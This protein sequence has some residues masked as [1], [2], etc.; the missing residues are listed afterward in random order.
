[1]KHILTYGL[2]AFVVLGSLT[3]VYCQDIDGVYVNPP[4][5]FHTDEQA[6]KT[7]KT[8]YHR[9]DPIYIVNSLCKNRNYSAAT[10]WRLVNETVITFPEQGARL[11]SVGCVENKQFFIGVVPPYSI[12]GTHHL[13]ATAAIMLNRL[14]TVY[15]EFRSQDFQVIE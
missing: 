5:T 4:F 8:V 6:L 1:M 14:H 9:G 2:L 10:T 3:L 13:E 12:V 7:D 11:S 15:Y